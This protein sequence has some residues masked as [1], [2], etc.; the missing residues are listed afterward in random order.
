MHHVNV[1]RAVYQ[2]PQRSNGRDHAPYDRSHSGWPALYSSALLSLSV[3]HAEK[4]RT[5]VRREACPLTRPSPAGGAADSISRAI[6]RKRSDTWGQ[7][8]IVDNR[9]GAAGAMPL[10]LTAKAP[11]D[12]YT[13]LL[14][15]HRTPSMRP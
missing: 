13:I 5:R 8:V 1:A 10:D 4:H 12:G 3:G 15:V 14:A 6:A 2:Q 11:A 9:G 7:P